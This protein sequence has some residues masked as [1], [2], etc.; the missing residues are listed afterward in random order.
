M[1]RLRPT[2]TASWVAASGSA[3]IQGEN[4]GLLVVGPLLGLAISPSHRHRRRGRP[5]SQARRGQLRVT[6][7]RGRPP[8]H[9]GPF[10]AT[11]I[12]SP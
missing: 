1:A 2:A 12:R 10:G 8:D 9:A 3:L 4:G 11:E 6:V 5:G 7:D